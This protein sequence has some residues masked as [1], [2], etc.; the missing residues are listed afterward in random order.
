MVC[1]KSYLLEG[2]SDFLKFLPD[3]KYLL[4]QLHSQLCIYRSGRKLLQ[5]NLKGK[6]PYGKSKE[7]SVIQV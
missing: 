3:W 7:Y 2:C 5:R 6:N 1:F 4:E